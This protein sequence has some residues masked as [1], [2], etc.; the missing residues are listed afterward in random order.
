MNRRLSTYLL[1][2][3]LFFPVP[4]RAQ[5]GGH[6]LFGDI[7]IDENQTSGLKPIFVHVLLY[8]EDG[9]LVSRQTVASNGR[10]RFNDLRNGRYDVVVE[11]ENTEIARVRVLVNAPFKT[12]FRQDL[13]FQW[14]EKSAGVRAEVISATDLYHRSTTNAALF[15]K[16]TAAG[17]KKRFDEAIIL[18]RQIVQSDPKDF[19]AWT[20]LGTMYFIQK[21]FDEA[22][23][24][25]T[26]ALRIN[27]DFAAAL[28][29]FGRIRIVRQDYKG[30]IVAL[31]HAV[32]VQPTSAQA[33][34]FLG[35][36]Y[37]QEKLGSKAVPYL[38]EAIR[39]DPVGMAEAHLRL[40]ALYHGA[41]M[42][43][44]AANEYEE[45]LKK[46]PDYPDRVRL[47]KYIAENK[48]Q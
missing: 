33:N 5:A 4:V 17:E 38:N 11:V 27:A 24:S 15:R 25:Y 12:D 34:Y 18:L 3:L 2:L 46:Q 7:K 28:I 40:A 36:A 10:Y 6:T 13:E 42:K 26:E 22:E 21:N 9:R 23:K 8:S 20:E 37:L 48:K 16:A 39:L 35:E 47:E 14:T 41:G 45:F 32:Q 44:K 29:C 31:T 30:A 19:P 43:D 1:L